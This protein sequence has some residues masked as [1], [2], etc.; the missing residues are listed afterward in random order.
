MDAFDK[1]QALAIQHELQAVN[2]RLE[3][4]LTFQSDQAN[5]FADPH[6]GILHQL[7]TLVQ[8][9]TPTTTPKV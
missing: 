5:R 7:I 3:R 8:N 1:A 6:I 9:T 4:A 2:A